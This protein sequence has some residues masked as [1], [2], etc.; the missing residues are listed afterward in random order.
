[1]KVTGPFFKWFGSKWH[2]TAH[3]PEPCFNT[4]IE[5]FAGSASYSLHYADHDVVIYDANCQLLDLWAWLINSATYD[6]IKAIPLN[7]PINTDIRT[8]SLDYGQQLL[9]KHWQRTNNVSKTWLISKWTNQPG[10]WTSNTRARLAEQIY[11][12]KHWKIA[13]PSFKE[14]G[15]YFIDPP[16]QYNY[17][18]KSSNLLYEFGSNETDYELLATSIKNLPIPNQVIVCEARHPNT[19][20]KPKWLPFQDFRESITCRR[21]KGDRLYSKELI[22]KSVN[23]KQ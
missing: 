16:Y 7:I 10:Q 18:Y 15:T 21:R 2:N 17:R 19:N 8:L 12:I 5:P 22:F 1:M 6:N 3:Y 9:L 11:A 23:I 20:V 14:C 4:I 13:M